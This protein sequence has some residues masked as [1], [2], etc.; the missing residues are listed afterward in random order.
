MKNW[1]VALLVIVGVGFSPPASGTGTLVPATF[2]RP[3]ERVTTIDPA[4]A[5]AVYDARAVGLLY[6]QVLNIDYYAR[7]YKLVPGVCKLPTVSEDGLTYTFEMNDAT[8]TPEE[9]KYSL[10]RLMD[11]SC[12][13]YWLVKNIDSIILHS[14]FFTIHLKHPQRVFPWLMAMPQASVM[15]LDG[16]PT[17]AF[18][19]TSWWKNHEMVF[20]RACRSATAGGDGVAALPSAA[21]PAMQVKYLV[22]DDA[23]T[24][25]LMF[26]RGE[27][28]MLAEVSRDNW[29]AVVG[30]DGALN[31][32]LAERGIKMYSMP[33]LE[34]LYIGINM[35][36]KVLGPNKKLRQA[37]NC[38]FD[39][40]KW[41]K[42]YQGRIVKS[43]S[44]VP[45]QVEGALTNDFAYAYNLEKA[46]Q[47]LAEAG[48]PGGIDPKTGRRLVL[49]LA[50]GRA[51]Q[52]SRESGELIAAFMNEIGIKLEL[53][54]YTW[55]AFLKAVNEGN[56]QLFRM[57]WV[58]DYP[59]AE[60]FLQLFYSKN[61][62]PGPNHCN[63]VNPDF[64]AAFEKEDFKTCQ[65]IV[66]E[67]CPWIFTHVNKA[68]SLVW[69]RVKNFIPSDFP[70]GQ[71]AYYGLSD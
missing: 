67:D 48:Y 69:P 2:T 60:N 70:Y 47:L 37:L 43:V 30:P 66:R 18:T 31:P 17:G 50:I 29:D 16:S 3:L 35:R 23:S 34:S 15:H 14:S 33:T 22:V 20:G 55:D 24:Q 7:P 64:D 52:D 11:P 61:V 54:F 58:G 44:P 8:I 6:N 62:S 38:A 51:S 13:N 41:E 21:S 9:V 5:Q 25:W 39:Y 28:D 65:E 10:S 57:G 27:L 49:T 56:V 68:N 46:K 71:E 26:L 63:Y 4:Q 36:D 40:P 12:P 32:A 42:F 19:L 45:P 53:K 59:D 1:W